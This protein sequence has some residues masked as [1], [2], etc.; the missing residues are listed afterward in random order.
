MSEKRG[1]EEQLEFVMIGMDPRM[2][3]T[4]K[5]TNETEI[6]SLKSTIVVSVLGFIH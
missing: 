3:I 5:R 2:S 1:Q 4:E 6:N